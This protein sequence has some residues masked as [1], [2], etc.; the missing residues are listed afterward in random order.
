MSFVSLSLLL[1]LYTSNN[2]VYVRLVYTNYKTHEVANL[3]RKQL[4]LWYKKQEH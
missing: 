2:I 4:Q 1:Y 3:R